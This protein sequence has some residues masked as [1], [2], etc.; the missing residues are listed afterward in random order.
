MGKTDLNQRLT[1]GYVGSW[2]H[3]DQWEKVADMDEIGQRELPRTEEEMQDPCEPV[4]REVFVVVTLPS[5]GK[6]QE[7][8]EKLNGGVMKVDGYLDWIRH[9]IIRALHDTYTKHGCS[10]EHD[11]CGCWSYYVR[12]AKRVTGDLWRVVVF[13]SRNY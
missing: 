1:R 13:A 4:T 2:Q 6:L 7:E 12:N 9:K 5:D 11:C 10:H 8:W 3:L